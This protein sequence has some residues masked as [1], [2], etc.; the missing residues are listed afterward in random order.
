MHTPRLRPAALGALALSGLLCGEG[1]ALAGDPTVGEDGYV[2]VAPNGTVLGKDPYYPTDGNGGYDVGD[3]TLALDYHPDS[4][5]LQGKATIAATA[6]QVLS[7]FDLD[8]HGLEVTAVRVD[9][10]DAAFAREGEHELVITPA[11]QLAEGAKFTVEVDYHGVP[12]ALPSERGDA[13]WQRSRSSG[14]FAVGAPHSA[15]TWFPVNDTSADKATVHLSVT[16]PEGW[17]VVANGVRTSPTSWA[18]ETPVAPSAIAVGIDRW[19]TDEAELPGG[20]PVLNAYAPDTPGAPELAAR[21]PEVIEFLSSKMGAYP[22]KAAGGIFRA[23]AAGFEQGTQSRPVFGAEAGLPDLVYANAFQWWGNGVTIKMWKDQPLVES[24]ARYAVWLWDE[25][26][27]GANL[28]QRYQQILDEVGD[29]PAFW[30]RKLSDPGA[31]QEFAA[32]DKG[33]LM[34]H[35]LRKRIGDEKFFKV[36]RGFPSTNRGANQGWHDWELYVGAVA[37]TDLK[38]FYEAWVEGTTRPS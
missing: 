5:E 29:D 25:A 36:L 20:V 13:G 26:K 18:E 10:Q 28:D 21:L 19:T 1:I 31:G 7:R 11:Q 22:Q 2:H 30:S 17:S 38:D 27:E 16:A 4:G 6:K 9:G 15:P 34:V 3:Y 24:H 14:A 8:L 12:A 23:D 35:A 33:V 32:A 37:N